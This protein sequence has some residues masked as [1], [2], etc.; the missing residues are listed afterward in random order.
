MFK[1]D[2]SGGGVEEAERWKSRKV[3]EMIGKHL[4]PSSRFVSAFLFLPRNLWKMNECDETKIYRNFE[5]E[6]LLQFVLSSSFNSNFRTM[7]IDYLDL[8]VETRDK[9]KN[10]LE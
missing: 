9:R 2:E 8:S 7:N 10:W 1:V 6:L 4:L 5:F 3:N